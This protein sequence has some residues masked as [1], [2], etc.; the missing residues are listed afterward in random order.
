MLIR[1]DKRCQTGSLYFKEMLTFRKKLV[2]LQPLQIT[3]VTKIE[4]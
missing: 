1:F 2:R 4:I 3:L